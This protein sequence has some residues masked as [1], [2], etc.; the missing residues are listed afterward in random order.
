MNRKPKHVRLSLFSVFLLALFAAEG[1]TQN[2][3]LPENVLPDTVLKALLNE[4]S[5]Q[6]PFNNEVL[7]GGIERI[8]S[9]E[10]F[11]GFFKEAEILAAKLKEY[12][13]DEVRV[14][15]LGKT[16]KGGGWWAGVDAELWI[17]SPEE[18]RISRLSECPALMTRNCDNGEWEG[19][20]ILLDRGMPRK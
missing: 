2:I 1:F 11:D 20:A 9:K 5:G 17:K 6:L 12:G 3:K 7:M 19:E 18:R 8:R 4:I 13:L 14:E 16:E 15:S 10:E